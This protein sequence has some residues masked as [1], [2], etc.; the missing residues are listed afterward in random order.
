MDEAAIV[1]KLSERANPVPPPEPTIPETPL[2]EPNPDEGFHDNLPLENT[3]EKL[4]L[5]DYFQIASQ[6]RHSPEIQTWLNTIISWA[7]DEAGSSEY[8]DM[9]RVINDQ[10]RV[11]GSKLKPDRMLRLWQF[12]KINTQRKQLIE[13]ERVLYG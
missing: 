2:E 7:R 9:L 4:N 1:A 8:T 13:R 10:E 3:L 6:N 12:V 11:M 5:M